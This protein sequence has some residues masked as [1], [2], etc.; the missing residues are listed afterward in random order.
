MRVRGRFN[1]R[2]V[3]K[4]YLLLVAVAFL[5]AVGMGFAII[6]SDHEEYVRT[7]RADVERE[8]DAATGQLRNW[9]FEFELVANRIESFLA[10]SPGTPMPEVSQ[11][12]ENL[13]EHNPQVFAVALAP[14]L[15]VSHSFP[16]RKNRKTIGLRYWEVPEQ[17]AS[18]ARAYRDRSPV[19]D[20]PVPLVQGGE[21]YILRYP[22]MLP[23]AG[24]RA[25]RFW[26]IIS[27]G[28]SAESLFPGRVA[29]SD[30]AAGAYKFGLREMYADGR[31]RRHLHGDPALFEGDAVIREISMLGSR[32]LVAA[33]PREGWPKYSPQSPMLIAF[34]VIGSVLLLVVLLTLRQVTARGEQAHA[35]LREAID[36]IDEGFIAFDAQERLV[37]VNQK[38]IDYH[39]KIADVIRPGL[40]FEA[41][42][43]EGVKRGQFP[44]AVGREDEWVAERLARFRKP[45]TP[46]QLKLPDERWLKVTEARTPHGYTVGVRTDVTAE[47]RAQAAAETTD[48]EKTEF[49]NNV[50]HELRTP[51]T[52]I[53]GR[54]AFLRH[55][56]MPQARRLTKAL[57]DGSAD[58]A[59]L[60]EAVNGYR[61]YVEEQSG[62]VL[63][64]SQH[65]LRLVEDLLDWT[66]V[67]RGQLELDKG[68]VQVVDVAREVVDDLRSEA[69]AKGLDLSYR[70]TGAAEIQADRIRLTQVLYN[71]V[72]NAIKFTEAGHI[73]L[74][75]EV[76]PE[77]VHFSV[78]DTGCG[79]AANDMERIFD[80]FKQVDGSATRQRG[81]LGL[82]LAIAKKLAE[83]HDGSLAAESVPGVGS[84]FRLSLP[85]AA[86]GAVE[87]RPLCSA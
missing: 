70:S 58:A 79:I 21:G 52:V 85:R 35:L 13:L 30:S 69:E 75:V 28:L 74:T 41:M 14:G 72:S 11:A 49:L 42:I 68:T 46:I 47:K 9:F 48:R 56:G 22:V 8:L 34:T 3:S 84:V 59:E 83:L 73:L 51:L 32:W 81:G 65:M 54:A 66:R 78:E 4:I 64:A 36:C 18:V 62:R 77:A 29:E 80:R 61:D 67:E 20:G 71:L 26:G 60:S 87:R 5:S 12:A 43:R 6:K 50:S 19:L 39:A 76:T 53:S 25:D 31:E 23:Q 45:D 38:F 82:G 86:A 15:E 57:G 17:M 10:V 1:R 27:I 2:L 44:E 55:E 37:I 24:A 63:T 16:V 40:P 7:I 33:E